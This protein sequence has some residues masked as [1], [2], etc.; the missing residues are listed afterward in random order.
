[1]KSTVSLDFDLSMQVAVEMVKKTEIDV[2]IIE[3]G[4]PYLMESWSGRRNYSEKGIFPGTYGSGR[5]ENADAGYREAENAFLGGGRTCNLY[6]RY[7]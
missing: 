7:R 3:A 6:Y 5:F 1:M 2:D 4:T